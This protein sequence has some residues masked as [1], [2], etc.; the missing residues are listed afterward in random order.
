[1]MN[2]KNIHMKKKIIR[3]TMKMPMQTQMPRLAM[4]AIVRWRAVLR[5]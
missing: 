1:M 4:L 2:L 5:Y 3:M